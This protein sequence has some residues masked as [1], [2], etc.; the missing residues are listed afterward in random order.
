MDDSNSDNKG[1]V[2]I[3]CVIKQTFK[4]NDYKKCSLNNEFILKSQ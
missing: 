1:K 4:F 2:G 3:I